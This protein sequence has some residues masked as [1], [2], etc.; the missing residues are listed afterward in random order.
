VGPEVD[1]KSS[2]G[3]TE[4]EADAACAGVCES[5]VGDL[6]VALAP[7]GFGGNRRANQDDGDDD[8]LTHDADLKTRSVDAGAR[9]APFGRF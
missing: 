1:L 3:T 2:Q 5:A 6:R 8:P 7:T 9:A 4:P